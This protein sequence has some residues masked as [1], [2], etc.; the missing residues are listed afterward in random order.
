MPS[1]RTLSTPT[2]GDCSAA[3]QLT[4]PMAQ[5]LSSVHSTSRYFIETAEWTW[6]AFGMDALPSIYPIQVLYFKEIRVYTKIRAYLPLQP[7]FKLKTCFFAMECRP[8][9]CCQLTT[10]VLMYITLSV[11][12]CLQ[13]VGRDAKRRAVRLRRL[14]LVGKI[15]NHRCK[16]VGREKKL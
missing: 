15:K 8:S 10:T 16:N 4:C 7:C 13:H 3:A 9:R 14:R 12:H 6:L 5:C 1:E 2:F 11:H